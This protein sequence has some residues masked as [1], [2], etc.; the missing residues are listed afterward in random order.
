M[1]LTVISWNIRHLRY[2]KVVGYKPLIKTG[3]GDGHIAFLYEN[4]ADK[5]DNPDMWEKLTT[6]MHGVHG[7]SEDV[8]IGIQTVNVGTNEHVVVLYTSKRVTGANSRHG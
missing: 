8:E 2:E 5:P 7:K 6:I 4:K 1:K 3:L